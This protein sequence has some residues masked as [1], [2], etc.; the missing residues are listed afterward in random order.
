VAF[1]QNGDLQIHY[2]VEGSGP[3]VVLQHGFSDSLE[4]W[5][6]YGYV[7]ALAGEH[8]VILVDCRGHGQSD[9][10]HDPSLYGLDD[11]AGDVVLLPHLRKL[12]AEVE[13]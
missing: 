5:R 4:S 3:P 2:E 6:E 1:A 8:Q 9:K 7:D 13:V 10:P 12:M 11:M